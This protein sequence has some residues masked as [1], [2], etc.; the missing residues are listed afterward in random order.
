MGYEHL[1]ERKYVHLDHV[2][3][4]SETIASLT[5][6]SLN[7]TIKSLCVILSLVANVLG[8][9]CVYLL[10][11]RAFLLITTLL[12]VRSLIL[13]IRPY[14]VS[15]RFLFAQECKMGANRFSKPIQ[16]MLPYSIAESMAVSCHKPIVIFKINLEIKDRRNLLVISV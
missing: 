6:S 8:Y 13:K 10:W 5:S 14:I 11:R 1:F 3:V 15:A 2:T 7:V 12:G 9:G 4:C 16:T